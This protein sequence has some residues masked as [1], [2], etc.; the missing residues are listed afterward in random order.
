MIDDHHIHHVLDNI[1]Y[2]ID[3]FIQQLNIT[4]L[5]DLLHVYDDNELCIS[6]HNGKYVSDIPINEEVDRITRIMRSIKMKSHSYDIHLH[7]KLALKSPSSIKQISHRAR[8]ATLYYVKHHIDK[9][10]NKLSP[11]ERAQIDKIVKNRK[12][13]VTSMTN[14]MVNKI[15]DIEHVRLSHHHF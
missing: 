13:L 9:N 15:R 10:Y 1:E 8:A 11:M 4:S 3:Q 7:R 14:K 12:G 6:D 2:N 5:E